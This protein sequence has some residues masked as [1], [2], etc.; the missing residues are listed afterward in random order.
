MLAYLKNNQL[1]A[2]VAKRVITFYRW[3]NMNQFDE[4]SVLSEICPRSCVRISSTTCTRARYRMPIFAGCSSQF[5]TEISLRMSPISFPQFQNVYC[6]GELGTKMYFITKGSVALIL[7]EVMGQPN[8]DDFIQLADSCVELC[9]GSFFERSTVLGHPS[10]LETIVTT[11]SSTMMTLGV[12]DMSDLC[13]LS[14]EFKAKLCIIAFER[15]RRNRTSREIVEY[16]AR[17]FGLDPDDFVAG[18]ERAGDDD[19]RP[20][21]R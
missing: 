15:M 21:G 11:R 9:R 12:H 16:C 18:T 5:M 10:R 7:R 1:P 17:E 4:K 3:Q 6:Q 8:Q 2:G 20:R 14:F 13:Q 19:P